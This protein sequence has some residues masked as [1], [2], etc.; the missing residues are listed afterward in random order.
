MKFSDLRFSWNKFGEDNPMWAIMTNK[1]D[2]DEE[3]FFRTG[4]RSIKREMKKLDEYGIPQP[5]GTAL[6][7]GCGIGRL[8]RAL[9]EH[10][11]EV[12]GVDIA[13]S[14]I[15]MAREKNPYPDKCHYH[16]NEKPDLSL[17]EDGKFDLVLTFIVLQHMSPEFAR[18]YLK[19]FARVLKQGGLLLFQLPSAAPLSQQA[20]KARKAARESKL[21]N[22]LKRLLGM[23]QPK[24]VMEMNWIP[25]E[26]MLEFLDG[27]GMEVL[28]HRQTKKAGEGWVSYHYY[29][30]KR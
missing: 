15:K 7:F 29:A 14:M 8:S 19:E 22:R 26:E 17:F 3:D 20:Q 25:I 12:H 27:I 13:E 16:L 18:G 11:E 2:W 24:A 28:Q 23:T 5:T 1:D 30:R 21:G 9:C 10:F 6:D 4:Q